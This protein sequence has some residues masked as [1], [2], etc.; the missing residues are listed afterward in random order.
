MNI[1]KIYGVTFQPIHDELTSVR[2]HN[3][4]LTVDANDVAVFRS[5]I[6]VEDLLATQNIGGVYPTTGRAA[7]VNISNLNCTSI[8][9]PG[10]IGGPSSGS[11]ASLVNIAN[12]DLKLYFDHVPRSHYIGANPRG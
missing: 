4:I 1:D 5:S 7:L 3:M 10:N 6:T 2:D 9:C 11:R 8:T 12:L